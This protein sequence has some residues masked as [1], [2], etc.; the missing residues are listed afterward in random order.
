MYSPGKL[1]VALI[2]LI[3]LIMAVYNGALNYKDT[4]VIFGL[5]YGLWFIV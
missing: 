4:S 1:S 2:Y 5:W 3:N